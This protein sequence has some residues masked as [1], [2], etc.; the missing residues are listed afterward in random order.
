MN[1][2]P[3]TAFSPAAFLASAGLGRRIIELAPQ[4]NFYSQGDAA[5]AVFYLQKGRAKLT[6]VSKTGEGSHHHS[7]LGE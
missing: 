4:E 7:S 5:D 3:E 2:V 6:V 1:S